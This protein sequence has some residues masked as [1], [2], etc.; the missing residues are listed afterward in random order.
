[1]YRNTRFT[2]LMKALPRQTVEKVVSEHKAGKHSKGFRCWNQFLAMIY[3]QVSGYQSLRELEAGFNS[4]EMHHYHLCC[5]TIK[6]STLS[7]ANK[8]RS[9][10]VFADICG[11]LLKREHKKV[12]GELSDLLYFLDSTPI[13]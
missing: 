10:K 12:K 1:M 11:L 8:Y 3:A 7:D 9:S 4:Q 5:R 13:L 6:R 2:E